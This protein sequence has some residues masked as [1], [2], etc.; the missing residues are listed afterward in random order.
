MNHAI[1]FKAVKS[2]FL[3][4][5][6][7]SML[8]HYIHL[9]FLVLLFGFTAILGKLIQIE[10]LPLVTYRTLIGGLGIAVLMLLSGRSLRIGWRHLWQPLLVGIVVGLHWFCFFHAVKVSN[11][12]VTLG[13]MAS[14]T[15]FTALIEAFAARRSPSRLE[16]GV[17][18]CI[19]LGLYVLTRFAFHYYLGVFYA[20]LA[21]FLASLF[22]VCN[23]YLTKR[24]D[25]LAISF[26]EMISACLIIG[27][28]A[29]YSGTL[30]PPSKVLVSDWQ[31]LLVLAIACTSYAFAAMVYLMRHLSAFDVTLAI[32]MEPIYGII[33]AWSIFGESEQMDGGFY[34]GAAIIIA[35]VLGYPWYQMKQRKAE[36]NTP[37]QLI[38][39]QDEA[40]NTSQ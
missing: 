6:Y 14:S 8:K 33:L 29:W 1:F 16:L 28:V 39:Q 24:H 40:S 5:N 31:Y 17:S 12:S 9:H 32:N 2:I 20:L 7:F 35:S 25:P 11:V 21:A 18:C 22:A 23:S 15:L 13:C 10:S 3:S 38:L 37:S 27:A 30:P 36:Q 34:V 4:D 26:F 19:M